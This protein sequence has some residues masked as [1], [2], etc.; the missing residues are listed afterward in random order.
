M[1]ILDDDDVWK[2]KNNGRKYNQ[3]KKY[4]HHFISQ[5]LWKK[6]EANQNET[7]GIEAQT[8]E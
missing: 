7:K 8:R 3:N 6:W 1:V 4:N 2:K 5:N